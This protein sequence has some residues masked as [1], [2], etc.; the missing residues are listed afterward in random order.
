VFRAF[1]A[2]E[3]TLAH[4]RALDAGVLRLAVTTTAR[5][6][7]PR[8]L[9]EFARMH[10]GI[11]TSL[12]VENRATL[13]E[14]LGRNE[15]DLY[16]FADPPRERELM[17]Q[18]VLPNPLVVLARR[19]HPLARRRRIPFADMAAEPF[20]MR[21]PG[22]GTR[23]AVLAQF[24]SRGLAPHVRMELGDNESIREAILAGLGISILSRY[25]LASEGEDGRLACLDVEGFPLES[26]WHFV[27]PLG[28]QLSAAAR[29]FM[30][31][32]RVEAKGLARV[33]VTSALGG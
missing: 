29:A 1:A 17:T 33:A 14:R 7:A 2:L 12:R 8:L 28:K 21:E 4:V 16:L 31:F 6:F 11:E 5:H 27:Y 26:Y 18:A 20:L 9:G 24:A 32:T 19:D 10:P 13:L 22:S 15:D 25:M 23:A 30:D 3:E